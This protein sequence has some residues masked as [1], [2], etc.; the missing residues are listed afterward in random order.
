MRLIVHLENRV[1]ERKRGEEGFCAERG[2][3]IVEEE[4]EMQGA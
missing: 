1:K 2:H 3:T 4:A